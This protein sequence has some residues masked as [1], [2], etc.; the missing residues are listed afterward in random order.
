MQNQEKFSKE[1]F[2]GI[3]MAYIDAIIMKHFQTARI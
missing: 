3:N 1:H 2:N